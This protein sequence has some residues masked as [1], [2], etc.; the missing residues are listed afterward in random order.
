MKPIETRPRSGFTLIEVLVVIAIIATMAAIL[1]PV[2]ARARIS[3]YKT[4]ALSNVKQLELARQMYLSDSDGVF[5]PYFSGL[6]PATHTYHPPQLYWPSLI[7]P[8]IAKI[9]GHGPFGQAETQD[10]PAVFWDPIK[11][12]KSQDTSTFKFGIY[13]DWGVSD[14]IVDWIAP[15]YSKPTY[16]PTSLS[17]ISTPAHC[18]D[19]LETWDW[20]SGGKMPGDALAASY[21]DLDESGAYASVD[22]PYDADQP[23]TMRD[24][25]ADPKGHNM[26]S[27]A[28]GH[29]QMMVVG[30]LQND[31]TLWSLSGGQHWR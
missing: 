26:C 27:F 17:G 30:Q 8:Y 21:F 10:L 20:L 9:E 13:A 19:L 1:F 4:T 29:V 11:P 7:L 23:K 12:M 24:V 14:D 16:Q 3:A 18:L 15:F 25:P 31:P 2:L 6:D 28:D 5:A 22:A